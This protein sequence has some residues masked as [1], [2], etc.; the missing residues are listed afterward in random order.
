[1]KLLEPVAPVNISVYFLTSEIRRC[2]FRHVC[3]SMHNFLRLLLFTDSQILPY[4]W[5]KRKNLWLFVLKCTWSKVKVVLQ[6]RAM[7]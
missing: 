7:R 4:V 5:I 1:M 2:R 3:S 6:I